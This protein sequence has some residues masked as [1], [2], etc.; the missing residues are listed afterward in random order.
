MSLFVRFRAISNLKVFY[1]AV[2]VCSYIRPKL[3]SRFWL[4]VAPKTLNFVRFRDFVAP[5]TLYFVRFRLF[6][7]PK[8]LYFGLVVYSSDPHFR[9]P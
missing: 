6:V 8:T 2:L 3:H 5:K 1:F 7:A 9:V 4:F